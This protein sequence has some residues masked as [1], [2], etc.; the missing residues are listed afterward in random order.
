VDV[1]CE[2]DGTGSVDDGE[3]S[4]SSPRIQRAFL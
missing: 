1:A 3:D 4:D 2:D